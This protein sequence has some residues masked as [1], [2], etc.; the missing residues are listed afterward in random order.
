[1]ARK[2]YPTLPETVPERIVHFTVVD[3]KHRPVVSKKGHSWTGFVPPERVESLVRAATTD[4]TDD[5]GIDANHTIRVSVYD[6]L[7]I[8]ATF[9][10]LPGLV[11]F[12][13]ESNPTNLT[14]FCFRLVLRCLLGLVASCLCLVGLFDSYVYVWLFCLCD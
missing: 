4:I 5:Q 11:A 1:M 7:V 10:D 14:L 9:I 13:D 2:L 12:Q 6:P 3:W 8:T